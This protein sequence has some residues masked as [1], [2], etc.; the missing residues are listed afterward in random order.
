[1]KSGII[2]KYKFRKTDD[3]RVKTISLNRGYK[4]LAFNT[5]YD[6]VWSELKMEIGEED[7]IDNWK[8]I[9]ETDKE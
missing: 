7:D 1:M 2:T 9:V 4:L 8:M 6:W 3:G 5:H